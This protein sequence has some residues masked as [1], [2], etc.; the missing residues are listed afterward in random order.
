M[1]KKPLVCLVEVCCSKVLKWPFIYL[2]STICWLKH[3][4]SGGSRGGARVA[5]PPPPLFQ[6]KP[7]LLFQGLEPPLR[8]NVVIFSDEC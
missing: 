5:R 4:I 7:R 1:S 8:Y 2:K 6:I 3:V